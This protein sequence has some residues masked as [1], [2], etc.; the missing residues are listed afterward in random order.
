MLAAK[1]DLGLTFLVLE[2]ARSSGGNLRQS[3]WMA[4]PVKVKGGSRG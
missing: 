1:N 4:H 3:L 2:K